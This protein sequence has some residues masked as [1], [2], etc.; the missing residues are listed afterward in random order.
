MGII[1][2]FKRK[3]EP[4]LDISYQDF[5]RAM[6]QFQITSGVGIPLADK[7]ESYINDGYA[8]NSDVYAIIQKIIAMS[9][10]A[11]IKLIQKNKDGSESEV[12]GHPLNEFLYFVNSSMSFEQFWSATHIFKLT[13]GNS[14]WYKPMLTEGL[15]KGKTLELHLMPAQFTEIISGD[16]LDPVKGYQLNFN[17]IIHIEKEKVYHQKFFDPRF[18][19][20]FFL[21]GLSPIKA[22]AQVVTKLNQSETTQTKAFENSSPPYILFRKNSGVMGQY[23]GLTKEQQIEFKKQLQEYSKD[24]QKGK[25]MVTRF[26]PDI[27]RLGV[28]P[29]DL[30]V[31]EASQDGLRKL[32]NIYQFPSVLMNDNA[33]STYNNIKEARK[34]A[35][36]DCIVP[37]NRDFAKDMTYFL[38]N[39]IKEYEPF[40]F[41]YDF[42]EVDELQDGIAARVTW[43]SRAGW[44]KNEI[45][46]ATGKQRYEHPAMDEPLFIQGEV[47]LSDVGIA[48]ITEQPKDYIDYDA[49]THQED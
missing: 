28:S 15:N 4:K 1:D 16:W 48:Q 27:I 37:L 40:Y 20:T 26:E 33:N 22:A 29:A 46:Q 36:T 5:L 49:K 38:T 34:A 21:Y 24:S 14:Y 35:W 32:C 41:V 11:K 17:P 43:M 3:A 13:V 9:K 18:D 8:C 19:Q 47:L 31:I 2:I 42:S 45:R 23:E 44:T 7:P 10:Q 25:P 30:G 39:G 6:Y 12:T